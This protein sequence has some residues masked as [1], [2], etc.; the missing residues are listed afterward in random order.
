MLG[1]GIFLVPIIFAW[2][3]LRQGYSTVSR[4]INMVGWLYILLQCVKG[5][6]FITKLITINSLIKSWLI[7]LFSSKK[8]PLYKS[9]QLVL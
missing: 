8:N 9:Y 3:T 1:I 5:C 7:T 6:L 4:G 2:L